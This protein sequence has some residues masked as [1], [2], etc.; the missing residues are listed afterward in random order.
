L[1][2]A[3]VAFLDRRMSRPR[4]VLTG[5]A[6]ALLLAS[7]SDAQEEPLRFEGRVTDVGPREMLVAV[8]NGPVVLLDLMRIPQGEIREISQNDYVIVVGFIRRPSHKVIATSI[9]RI[10]PWYPT[11]PWWAPQ[12][13]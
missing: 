5:F 3:A 6:L 1:R 9:K 11:T 4:A 2:Y 10:S 8:E 12:S 7:S 13:P